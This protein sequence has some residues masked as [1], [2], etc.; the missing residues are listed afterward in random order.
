[1]YT[2]NIFI[3]ESLFFVT[4]FD[5]SFSLNVRLLNVNKTHITE[6]PEMS[7]VSKLARSGI[8]ANIANTLLK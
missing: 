7:K 2:F 1:M 3:Q 6:H 5:Y 4:D 8:N